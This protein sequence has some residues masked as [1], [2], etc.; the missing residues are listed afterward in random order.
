M[1]QAP[2]ILMWVE[3]R[4]KL[5]KKKFNQLEATAS[6]SGGCEGQ[7]PPPIYQIELFI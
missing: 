6:Q 3:Q 5:P 2:R 4:T 1:K 7:S